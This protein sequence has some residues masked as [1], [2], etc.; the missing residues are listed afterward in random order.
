MSLN[1][2]MSVLV[3]RLVLFNACRLDLLEAPLWQVDI[4]GPQI[5]SQSHM[6]QAES[7]RQCTN[8]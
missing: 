3:A 5:A 1:I 2:P 7:T 8:L 6:S 4:S